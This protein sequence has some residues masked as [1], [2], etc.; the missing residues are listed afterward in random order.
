MKITIKREQ[1]QTCLNNA[2]REQFG[3]KLK[4]RYEKPNCKVYELQRHSMLLAGSSPD[5][6][7]H[8]G[9]LGYNGDT[10]KLT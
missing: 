9:W 2:K 1:S 3:A 4:K 8:D 5:A 6:P 10:N 7:D